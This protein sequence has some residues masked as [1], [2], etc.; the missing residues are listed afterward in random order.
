MSCEITDGIALDCIEGMGGVRTVWVLG[1]TITSITLDGDQLITDV[2]GTGTYFK[3]ELPKDTASFTQTANISP[4][5]GTIAYAQDLTMNFT[6]LN[7]EVRNV[8]KVLIK[9]REL[10]VVFLDNNSNY[11]M[12]GKVRGAQATASTA[13][14]GTAPTDAAQFTVTLQG[15][16]VDPMFKF[17]DTLANSTTGITVE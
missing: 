8:L 2:T 5:N 17:A 6:K 16:E 10:N 11:W 3:F 12:I 15:M 4:V 13:V 7:N 9:N 14:T 1:G